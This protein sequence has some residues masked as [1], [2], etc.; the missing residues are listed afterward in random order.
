MGV[1]AGDEQAASAELAAATPSRPMSFRRLKVGRA[2]TVS[3][4]SDLEHKIHKAHK[5][6][7]ILFRVCSNVK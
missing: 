1:A 2:M 6:E 4:I 3:S 5:S 7:A